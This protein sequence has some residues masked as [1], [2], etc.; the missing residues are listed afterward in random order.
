M[1]NTLLLFMFSMAFVASCKDKLLDNTDLKDDFAYFPVD[2]G[3][4]IIYQVFQ[5]TIDKPSEV[6]DTLRWE[7]KEIISGWY[8][9]AANDTIRR[10]EIYTRPGPGFGWSYV[11][12]KFTAIIGLEALTL[13]DNIKYIALS[14]PVSLYKTW[15]GNRYNQLDTLKL[16][17]FQYT[18]VHF[19]AIVFQSIFDSVVCV[20]QKADSSLIHKDLNIEKY[21]KKIGLIHKSIVSIRSDQSDFDPTIPI[22]DRITTGYIYKKEILSYE[23][24]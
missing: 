7:Q 6:F 17:P 22:E 21:A 24:N 2:S 3:R 14:F 9:D 8:I 10:V 5:L 15:D 11:K 16:Y 12:T 20:T 13:E 19:P 1:R 18:S 4:A 23:N